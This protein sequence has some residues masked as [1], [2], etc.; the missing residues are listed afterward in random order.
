MP[1]HHALVATWQVYFQD[2][3]P[4]VWQA[5]RQTVYRLPYPQYLRSLMGSSA[6]QME[7]YI[8]TMVGNFSEGGSGGFFFLSPDRRYLIKTLT[9][10]EQRTLLRMLPKYYEYLRT[11]PDTLLCR[12]YGCY[13]ITMHG[14]SV[15]F[16][17]MASLFH[18]APQIHEK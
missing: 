17:C 9:R 14:Q 12:F 15:Y 4:M 3:A 2:F 10:V 6:E 1:P 11:S 18:N 16:V 5:L 7:D 8:E 13:A